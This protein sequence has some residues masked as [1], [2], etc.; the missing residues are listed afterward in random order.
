[1]KRVTSLLLMFFITSSAHSQNMESYDVYYVSIGNAHYIEANKEANEFGFYP[2]N[3]AIYSARFVAEYLEKGGSKYGILLESAKGK[4]ITKSDILNAIDKVT[5]RMDFDSDNERLLVFYYCGHGLGE[6][7]TGR[8]YLVPGN[9]VFDSTSFEDHFLD[10]DELEKDL[11]Y[12]VDL[13]QKLGEYSDQQLVLLDNCYEEPNEQKVL[14]HFTYRLGTMLND[15]TTS[16][17]EIHQ[18]R[19]PF[20]TVF[21]ASVPGTAV[22]PV[23]PPDFLYKRAFPN[24]LGRI[25]RKFSIYANGI[26]R[27]QFSG[28][29]HSFLAFMNDTGLDNLSASIKSYSGESYYNKSFMDVENIDIA[30]NPIKG[31][32]ESKN[33]IKAEG[34][35]HGGPIYV[36]QAIDGSISLQSEQGDWIGSGKDYN[37]TPSKG[38]IMVMNQGDRLVV[39]FQEIAE[40]EYFSF[41][42][43]LPGKYATNSNTI[44]ATDN[45]WI[46]HE[47]V[48]VSA[49]G[50]AC[51]ESKGKLKV[52]SLQRDAL[53]RITDLKLEF[54][55][56]CDD[57]KARLTGSMDLVLEPV[58]K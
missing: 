7:I 48:E 20:S 16:L 13:L 56:I 4:Y 45:Y 51:S 10:L 19:D 40:Y 32:G 26:E 1:M 36:L 18:F 3:G 21:Y 24:L 52:I 33:L 5:D 53:D 23:K 6:A 29:Y 39:N 42:F 37:L 30:L 35:L 9:T 49:T 57:S 14:E 50:R 12:S 25:S 54:H 15:F 44:T 11:I 58:L 2:V 47:E 8:Q 41:E 38:E 17:R 22:R 55:H 28:D 31:T 46:D 27:N 43:L 34:K